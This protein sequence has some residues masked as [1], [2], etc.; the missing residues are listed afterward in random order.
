MG[1]A[2]Y[3]GAHALSKDSESSANGHCEVDK[4]DATGKQARLEAINAGNT[5]TALFVV[6]GLL[7]AGGVVLY[8]LGAPPSAGDAKPAVTAAPLLGPGTAGAALSGRF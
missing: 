7:T 5:S 2:G 6:G 1:V 4:C 8:I 3:F